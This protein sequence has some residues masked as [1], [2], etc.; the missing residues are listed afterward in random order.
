MASTRQHYI[1]RFLLKGF[2]CKLPQE[3]AFVWSFLTGRND[4]I[5]VSIRDIAL[6]KSFYG[7]P[8]D[9]TLDS[10]ITEKEKAFA[11]V[12]DQVRKN[13]VIQADQSNI[14]SQLVGHMVIRTRHAR[15]G[16]A[17]GM[18]KIIGMTVSN[19]SDPTKMIGFVK[20][21]IINDKELRRRMIKTTR[22]NLGPLGRRV[23][24]DFIIQF[25]KK[26]GARHAN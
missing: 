9:D 23:S 18:G 24:D 25:L 1:P 7:D 13:Q 12:L 5:K 26:L 20:N 14:L 17:E 19:L 15:K 16:F 22:K 6:E 2:S 21:H 10:L 3:K 11:E 8:G 4:A